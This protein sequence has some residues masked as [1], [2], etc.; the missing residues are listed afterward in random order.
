MTLAQKRRKWTIEEFFDWHERQEEKYELVNGVP[1]LKRAPVAVTLPGAN[2]PSMM[3]G[4]SRRHNMANSNLVRVIGNQLQG[5]PC[6]A[7]ANDAA[8][9][10][11][12]S[13]IRYPDLVVDC[14]TKLDGGYLFESP[15]LVAEVLSPSTKSFDLAG[16]ITEYWQIGTL[17]YV[18]IVDPDRLR[19]QLHARHTGET[20]TLLTFDEQEDVVEIA[21]L[22]VSLRLS[23]IFEGLVP[24]SEQ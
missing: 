4:A 19:V 7:F 1:V 8:V 12:P 21:E 11:G 23:D 3:T 18:L 16:K 13:Q 10:T 17:A 20:P 15:R 5:G 6:K 2:A 22:S 24:A 14:D 9:R